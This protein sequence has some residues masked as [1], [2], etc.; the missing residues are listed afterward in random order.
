MKSLYIIRHGETDF[1]RRGIVQGKGV[2]TDLNERG[3]QQA[4]AFF[5]AYQHHGFEK[6]Y[7]STL[8]RTYQT[9][10][11]FIK[12]NGLEWEKLDGLDEISW[13][14]YEGKLINAASNGVYWKMIIDW[15]S[16]KVDSKVPGGESPMELQQRQKI[17]LE[18]ILS[19]PGEC[20]LICTHGRAMR[21]FLCTLLNKDLSKMDDFPHQNLSLY[22]LNYTKGKFFVEQFNEVGHL[23]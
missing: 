14:K 12:Q 21:T 13:G 17:A 6:I 7:I 18:H 16:G 9:I 1:N 15:R 5:K 20:V 8:K 10:V 22:Q 4:D 2:D 19:E 23:K 11:P 3:F